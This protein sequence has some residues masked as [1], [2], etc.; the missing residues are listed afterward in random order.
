MDYYKYIENE[1]D[2]NNDDNLSSKY[3]Q[4]IQKKDIKEK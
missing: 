4:I 1:N 3:V 2:D